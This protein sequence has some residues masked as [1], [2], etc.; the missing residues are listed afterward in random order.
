[1]SYTFT[2]VVDVLRSNNGNGLV[3]LEG[4]DSE[5]R[6]KWRVHVPEAIGTYSCDDSGH[7]TVLQYINTDD[8]EQSGLGSNN[9]DC[10]I[11]V[12]QAGPVY[13]GYFSGNFSGE[14]PRRVVS[15][16]YFKATIENSSGGETGGE[17]GGGGVAG[18]LDNPVYDSLNG[19]NGAYL[20]FAGSNYRYLLDY[21]SVYTTLGGV[22]Q[23]RFNV[24][25][26]NNIDT[27][28]YEG[29]VPAAMYLN[30]PHVLGEQI[31]DDQLQMVLSMN[32][33][34]GAPANRG[35]YT[36][37][38]CRLRTDYVS[39]LGGIQGVILAAKLEK[40]D[41]A[42]QLE[43]VPFRVYDHEGVP[44]TLDG[45]LPRDYFGSIEL[46]D[47][48]SYELG[49]DQH[50][51]LDNPVGLGGTSPDDGTPPFTGNASDIISLHAGTQPQGGF[52]GD[53]TYH[54]GTEYRNRAGAMH[55]W[56]KVGTYLLEQRYTSDDAGG[57]CEI[58]TVSRGGKFYDASYTATLFAQENLLEGDDRRLEISGKFRNYAVVLTR[59]DNDS[60]DE[61]ELAPDEV[62]MTMRVEDG[63]G[64]WQTGDRFKFIYDP[65]D[66]LY[67]Y[68]SSYSQYGYRTL[69]RRKG[70]KL[71]V[72]NMPRAVGV[73]N[74]ADV[75]SADNRAVQVNLQAIGALYQ[76]TQ[77]DRDAKAELTLDGAACQVEILTDDNGYVTGTYTATALII[78]GEQIMPSGDNV[79]RISGSF[80]R[81]LE[82]VPKS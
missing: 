49:S 66:Q 47:N 27:T 46:A 59:P 57:E 82:P 72:I 1:M 4:L 62:G 31:C 2:D 55:M 52:A 9:G 30:I 76:T 23:L 35:D 69:D 6:E 28:E 20:K 25:T 70:L 3:Y 54:C 45:D 68:E 29:V 65:F 8:L 5:R 21:A 38:D 77:Y 73:Y 26:R 75:N 80:R 50:F 34:T 64:H 74:C 19:K 67:S 78:D 48:P 44:G 40:D 15:N 61:G 24:D 63:S 10:V 42:I 13:E 32:A 36:A 43:N 12:V 79:V 22:R 33:V 58:V 41:Y 51:L 39:E 7:D 56:V 11:K 60:G 71:D 18:E 17:T 81:K 53:A 14:Q 37:S 16:G